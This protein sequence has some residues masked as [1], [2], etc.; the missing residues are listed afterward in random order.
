[1]NKYLAYYTI[2]SLILLSSCFDNHTYVK[3]IGAKIQTLDPRKTRDRC[4]YMIAR[5]IYGQ[6]LEIN[7]FGEIE[8]SAFE[9]W[10]V[11]D[12]GK[13][14]IFSL[15]QN[16]FFHSGKSLTV[17]DV[18]FTI[19]FLASK[20]SLVS[21]FFSSIEGYDDFIE[22]KAVQIIG[23]KKID[24]K[25]LQI[26][27]KKPS[28][29]FL[30]ML[31]DL[32][33]VVLPLNLNDL[34]EEVFFQKPDGIGPYVLEKI[35][36]DKSELTLKRYDRY[37]KHKSNIKYYR[38]SAMTEQEALERFLKGSVHDLEVFSIAKGALNGLKNYGNTFSQ[39]SYSTT[40]LFFNGRKK[41]FQDK[42]VRKLIY[43]AIDTKK[44]ETGCD[45]H[46]LPSTGIIPHG[47]MGWKDGDEPI[48]IRNSL[49]TRK[50]NSIK[51]ISYGIKLPDC[52][53][54]NIKR[55]LEENL[56]IKVIYKN[57]AVDEMPEVF[58]SGD[59]D[60]LFD[61]LSIRGKDPYYLFT[62]FDPASPQSITFFHDSNITQMLEKIEGSP[63]N[64]RA[65]KYITLNNY[66]I[67]TNFYAIP[68]YTD[69]K[70]YIFNKKVKSNGIPTTLF[71]N[72]G[73]ERINL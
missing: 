53:L 68:L 71:G 47:V 46:T 63:A 27:L 39:S 7:D 48:R 10:D 43:K 69:L 33:V 52:I 24:S 9:S 72:T 11:S 73:L 67:D 23:V 50:I 56:N 70:F 30:D 45:L 25:H 16:I 14:Y 26:N 41:I 51:L 5:S 19:N 29:I 12:D 60:L 3:P 4:D 40:F 15:R 32:K 31:A 55:Q 20:G 44:L 59:Y 17:D 57:I 65:Q 1:M 61:S 66:I 42:E 6:F 64:T 38:I 2:L 62:Y 37:F 34:S 58:R 28:Y 22:K 49:T 8:P 36:A 13:S 35:S 18:I 21:K 54:K